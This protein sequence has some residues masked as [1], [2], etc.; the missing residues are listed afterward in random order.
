MCSL[1]LILLDDDYALPLAKVDNAGSIF[2]GSLSPESFGDY[3][4]GTNHSA[5]QWYG[6]SFFWFRN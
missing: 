1:T 5:N 2:C 3:S 4:S 6:K